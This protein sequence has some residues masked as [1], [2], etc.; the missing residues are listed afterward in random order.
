MR[1]LWVGQRLRQLVTFAAVG[2]LATAIQYVI[3]MIG[4]EFF[5]QSPT[6]SSGVGF[7]V[8]AVVNYLL[9]YRFTFRSS[10]AHTSTVLRFILVSSVGLLLN[11][12]AMHLLTAVWHVQYVLAQVIATGFVFTWTFCGSAFWTFAAGA[13]RDS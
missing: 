1:W 5:G 13:A 4:V 12:V 3:L 2:L 9:N 7:T 8:S 11:V 6:L 10:G